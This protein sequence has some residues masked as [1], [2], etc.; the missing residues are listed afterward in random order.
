[1]FHEML[2]G[3]RPFTG[4]S[5][6]QLMSSILRDM[7]ASASEIRTDVPEA[8][9]RLIHRC[10]EKRPDDRVQTARDIYNE[11][12]HVQ[13]Q[14]ESGSAASGQRHRHRAAAVA[15]SLWIAVLPFTTRGAD[16]DG[17]ALAAGLTEDITAGLS[18]VSR[19]FGG[20]AAVGAQLQGFAARRAADRRAAGRALHH[21]RQRPE[22]G[23][24]HPHR[25]PADRRA[26]AARSCG[27]RPTIDAWRAATFTRSRTT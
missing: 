27:A 10:L 16:P 9:S 15:D 12:R 6:P 17:E 25:R 2:T 21:G 20:R 4:E 19:P 1:M 14:L 18:R 5:S 26:A 11:L 24:R 7:P 8:L 13:K 23:V 3:S 22:V